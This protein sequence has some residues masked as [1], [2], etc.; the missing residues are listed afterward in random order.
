MAARS[1]SIASPT[2]W[3]SCQQATCLVGST[4]AFVAST[5]SSSTTRVVS[6]QRRR[7]PTIHRPSILRSFR[8]YCWS[9][10]TAFRNHGGLGTHDEHM[11]TH[12]LVDWKS[13]ASTSTDEGEAVIQRRWE[14][15]WDALKTAPAVEQT[16]PQRLPLYAGEVDGIEG[17]RAREALSRAWDIAST[18][19]P[20]YCRA[21]VPVAPADLL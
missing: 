6:R 7:R 12:D 2:T 9:S 5:C 18:R 19:R 15:E 4:P 21:R 16:A 11:A 8:M 14:A 13:S 1:P 10:R 17:P 20:L 3:A